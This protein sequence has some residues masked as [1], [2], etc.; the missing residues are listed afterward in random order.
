M[1]RPADARERG[2]VLLFSVAILIL[3][4]VFGVVFARLMNLE[5]RASAFYRDRVRAKLA[6]RAG[7]ERAIVQLQVAAGNRHWSA[8][9]GP[10]W[11]ATGDRWGYRMVAPASL[12]QGRPL[13][14]QSTVEPSFWEPDPDGRRRLGS[15]L[16]YSGALGEPYAKSILIYR[17]KI[18]DAASMVN[19]NHPDGFAARRMLATLVRTTLGKS[20]S[21][22]ASIAAKAIPS[23]RQQVKRFSSKPQVGRALL[24]AGVTEDEWLYRLRDKITVH[25]WEDRTVVRPWNLNTHETINGH[26]V[27]PYQRLAAMPRAPINLNTASKEVLVAL[28]NGAEARTRYGT[29]ALDYDTAVRLADAILNRRGGPNSASLA[30]ASIVGTTPIGGSG[31]GTHEHPGGGTSTGT[32]GTGT[33]TG[34]PSVTGTVKPYRP[35]RTWPEFEQFIDEL[36]L[37]VFAS[38][39]ERLT[40]L[41]QRFPG[42]SQQRWPWPVAL[43]FAPQ[44]GFFAELQRLQKV[45]HRDLV[46]AICNPNTMVNKFGQMPNHGGYKGLVPRM[47]DK[48]DLVSMTTEACFDAMG[49]YEITSAGMLLVEDSRNQTGMEVLAAHTDQMVVQVYDPIRLTTQ[50]DFEDHRAVMVRGDFMDAPEARVV[51]GKLGGAMK[52]DEIPSFGRSFN[53]DAFFGNDD[54][55]D[56][57]ADSGGRDYNDN[58]MPVPGWPGMVSWPQY[59]LDRDGTNK[60]LR[61]KPLYPM[62]DWDGHLTLSNMITVRTGDSDFIAGFARGRLDAFKARAWWEPRD[63]KPNA[64]HKTDA[65]AMA[66]VPTRPRP[67][68]EEIEPLPSNYASELEL[69][70]RPLG[71]HPPDLVG[72]FEDEDSSTLRVRSAV[73]P[74]E[75]SIL[76]EKFIEPTSGSTTTS[77]PINASTD[78]SLW[79]RGSQLLNTGVLIAPDR[80]R[81][82]GDPL[83]LAYDGDNIDLVKGTSIRFWVQ[84]LRDPYAQETEVLL[85]FVGSNGAK[86]GNQFGKD[87]EVGFRVYKE[88]DP[89]SQEVRIVLEAV[90]REGLHGPNSES[91]WSTNRAGT[92]WRVDI[93]VTPDAANPVN[94]PTSP[95]WI[96]GTWHWVVINLGLAYR[97]ADAGEAPGF[98]YYATLQVDKSDPTAEL[99]FRGDDWGQNSP[100]PEYGELYGHV[101]TPSNSSVEPVNRVSGNTNYDKLGNYIAANH[102]ADKRYD[103]LIATTKG[104][105]AHFWTH[106]RLLGDFYHCQRYAEA[107]QVLPPEKWDVEPPAGDFRLTPFDRKDFG[108]GV[109]VVHKRK[110]YGAP[111]D[112]PFPGA[113]KRTGADVLWYPF[114]VSGSA[115]S[116]QPVAGVYPAEPHPIL[117]FNR[118][119]FLKFYDA[120]G[121]PVICNPWKGSSRGRGKGKGPAKGQEELEMEMLIA[122][123]NN[124]TYTDRFYFGHGS[125]GPWAVN[126]R[127]SGVKKGQWFAPWPQIKHEVFGPDPNN[128]GGL[129]RGVSM[130]PFRRSLGYP[131][132]QEYHISVVAEW[133]EAH[134]LSGSDYGNE[135]PVDP[136]LRIAGVDTDL[137]EDPTT[138]PAVE[139][140][141]PQPEGYQANGEGLPYSVHNSGQTTKGG[142][143]AAIDGNTTITMT[144]TQW[145]CSQHKMRSFIRT[146]RNLRVGG[147]EIELD[148]VDDDCHGCEDCDVDGPVFIGGE[149]RFSVEFAGREKNYSSN[150][151]KLVL[152]AVDPDTMAYAVFDNVVFLNGDHRRRTDA[153]GATDDSELFENSGGEVNLA[154]KNFEDRFFEED[155]EAYLYDLEKKNL[156]TGAVYHR[157]L[158]EL[159]NRRVRLGSMTWTTYPT[160]YGLDYEVGLWRFENH[161]VAGQYRYSYDRFDAD[162]KPVEFLGERRETPDFGRH[163]SAGNQIGDFQ[164][165]AA[166]G[167]TFTQPGD[168]LTGLE[169]TSASLDGLGDPD[170]PEHPQELLILGIRLRE[171]G[172]LGSEDGTTREDI[173]PDQDP[174]TSVG[175]IQSPVVETPIVEDVTLNVIPARPVVLY[176][177][178]GVIE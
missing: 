75:A 10:P 157:A 131:G 82:D 23:A 160:T 71:G 85:S 68:G 138:L 120:S 111:G 130:P 34:G 161:Y 150:S 6:A 139:E 19:L 64:S 41:A 17:L 162:G 63:L 43:D 73:N 104:K 5:R 33:G 173:Q 126:L 155:L 15:N 134:Y 59:S 21:E 51:N 148:W 45:G 20:P 96:P 132:G 40:P 49:A 107:S 127:T 101:Y 60:Q 28:F 172:E 109:I 159:R 97:G 54:D 18:L 91:D 106:A 176:A 94:D 44:G 113:I 14:L 55:G 3:L 57:H 87:R 1:R 118:R 124:P 147:T 69:L 86:P 116:Y 27:E 53:V 163:D 144:N 36:P 89:L 133:D 66:A 25:S 98:H 115:G 110:E 105:I 77:P 171:L 76:G 136:R 37:S 67:P 174:G 177:E 35:F 30:G 149:P 165:D 156:G 58:L 154:A 78:S 26:E 169:G 88:A 164:D 9:W 11:D 168:P 48:T 50:R 125:Y 62:A 79:T 166:A 24:A 46:K 123:Q 65:T 117:S 102:N 112:A 141:A 99:V 39:S 95:Q 16:T 8:P 74:A 129:P 72:D 92:S 47:V 7:I 152:N 56:G 29:F 80:K 140:T 121:N 108:K 2:S 153:I 100:Q 158:M 167:I 143:H 135:D 4:S 128:G 122:G 151:G 142:G 103:S 146:K 42:G 61:P 13:D 12:E 22:S 90:G 93:P 84:P 70:T 145:E 83:S 175:V 119:L 38:C 114:V 52:L 137:P 178:E 31:G 81:R 170:D 32:T